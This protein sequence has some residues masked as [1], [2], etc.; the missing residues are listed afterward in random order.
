MAN[1]TM[2]K[3]ALRALALQRRNEVRER[4]ERS[5]RICERLAA[6]DLYQQSLALHCYLPMR[7]EAS[8]LP[9]LAQALA[10][11][12]RVAVPVT[13]R[14]QP[15]LEHS[16]LR[17]LDD[18]EPGAFGTP[19][20]RVLVPCDPALCDLVIVP[21]LGFDRHCQRLGYGKGH[22]DRLLATLR[23]P[24]VGVAFAAQEFPHIPPDPWDVALD[25]I[26]TEDEVVTIG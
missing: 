22:Y 19:Q 26:V 24:R 4:E 11:G 10:S 2:T 7:S 6:L 14:G 8:T 17:A 9:L 25:A 13:R 12:K 1:D 20:P 18:L 23:V 5:R 15:E 21:L 16:W 3:P